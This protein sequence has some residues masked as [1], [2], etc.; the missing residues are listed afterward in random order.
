[1]LN[2][3]K[4]FFTFRSILWTSYSWVCASEMQHLVVFSQYLSF[5]MFLADRL[6]VC[7]F[8]TWDD[9]NK[10]KTSPTYVTWFGLL[11]YC[12]VRRLVLAL[13]IHLH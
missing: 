4:A 2:F 1:M 5:L 8:V 10:L 3:F 11:I 13:C 9:H 12:A 6:S 7:E